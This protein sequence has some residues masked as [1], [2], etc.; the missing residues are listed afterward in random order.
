MFLSAESE[1]W[2]ASLNR[3]IVPSGY[4]VFTPMPIGDEEYT[5]LVG[6]Q[7]DVVV[8]AGLF[9]I[10]STAGRATRRSWLP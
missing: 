9:E 6:K 8:A 7:G 2:F 5:A 3:V 10:L 1:T 4:A